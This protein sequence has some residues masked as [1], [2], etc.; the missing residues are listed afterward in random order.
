[1]NNFCTIS[2]LIVL[3]VLTFISPAVIA[4]D[5]D[6]NA[7]FFLTAG[8]A[9]VKSD[10]FDIK[11]EVASIKIGG[12]YRFSPYAGF[13]IFY[14]YYGDIEKDELLDVNNVELKAGA[15][16]ANAIAIWPINSYIDLLGKVGIGNWSTKIKVDGTEVESE[17]NS[18]A[19]YSAGVGYNIDYDSTLRFEYEY[20]EKDGNSF[21]VFS[22][23][24]QHNF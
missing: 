21:S 6:R 3:T 1:M 11:E 22:F 12:G 17:K 23:G 15:A 9:T 5:R 14:I 13:E 18:S 4:E 24:F 10:D 7:N 20:S 16:V 8:H 2:I 19:I